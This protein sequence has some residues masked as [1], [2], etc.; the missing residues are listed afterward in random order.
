MNSIS[1]GMETVGSYDFSYLK[2][3]ENTG[4]VS[5]I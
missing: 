4:R 5:K 3:K 2:W 1:L